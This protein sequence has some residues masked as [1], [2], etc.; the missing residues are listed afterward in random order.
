MASNDPNPLVFTPPNPL[1]C[2]DPP[3]RSASGN[4]TISPSSSDHPVFHLRCIE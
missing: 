1:N 4:H 2:S 3:R